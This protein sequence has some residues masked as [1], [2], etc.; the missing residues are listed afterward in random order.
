VKLRQLTLLAVLL[1]TAA[2]HAS[3]GPA[4]TDPSDAVVRI[5]GEGV[6]ITQDSLG[7][8]FFISPDGAVLTCY[9]VVLG[10]RSIVVV[11][12]GVQ[13]R[14]VL[15][16][17]IA[18]EYDLAK[19]QV[20]NLPHPAP[21][22]PVTKEDPALLLNKSLKLWGDP[23]YKGDAHPQARFFAPATSKTYVRSG[24]YRDPDNKNKLLFSRD[25]DVISVSSTIYR[26]VS[27]APLIDDIRAIGVLSGSINEGGTEAWAIPAKYVSD[28]HSVGT[29]GKTAAQM[30]PW[31][32]LT[33]MSD[34]WKN[35][36]SQ[37]AL[38]PRL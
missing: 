3:P 38:G 29:P 20:L 21:Y 17:A 7:T 32:K 22:L 25:I 37:A 11:A 33:L 6:S 18:P 1:A 16:T 4:A 10:A 2:A 36:R 27:G 12:N 8:G 24:S 26:G 9:H 13:Y 28:L 14:K 31:P 15:V 19:L 35:V 5:I 23:S 30:A 34:N